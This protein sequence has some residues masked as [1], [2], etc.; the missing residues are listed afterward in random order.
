ML[1]FAPLWIGYALLLIFIAKYS[2][3]RDALLP[4][5]VSVAVQA[6][7]YVATYISAV[8]LVGFGGL[9]YIFGMQ[10]LLIAAGN[11]WLGTWFV[12]RYLAWPTRLWQRKLD[13]K[14]PAELLSKAFDAPALQS[15]IGFI[16]TVLL[17]IY[18]SAVFKGA[19]V[20]IAGVLPISVNTALVCLVAIVGMSVLW[21]GLRGVLYTEAF[22]GLLMIIGVG[23]LL[24]ALL[25]AVGGPA[26]GIK[27]LAALPPT[28][29]AN[30]GFMSLSSGPSGLNIIFLTLVTSVGI[31]AQP[32]LIQR[33]FALKSMSETKKAAPL[34]M[35]A[36]S[37]VVGGAY[38]A[39]ALSRLL[40]GPGI[41]NPDTV[42]PMLVNRL[43]PAF[44]QQLFAL[45]I[46]SASLSTASALL[47]IASGSLGRDVFKKQLT[48]W[49]WR[50]VVIFCTVCSGL[51][52]LKSS[53]IIA[54][55]CATS[56]TLLACAILVPYLALLIQGPKA[57][58]R[59]AL[60]SSA[61]GFAGT[62][63]WYILAYAP[64]SV[65]ITGIAAPGI[66]G[67]LHPLL[68]GI[69]VSFTVFMLF[70]KAW[71]TVTDKQTAA[72]TQ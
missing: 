18:G 63:A 47:H 26:A 42:M 39:S 16:S 71:T 58:G 13:S 59:A 48:G 38:F 61:G 72:D 64:T 52:A 21:G 8:A 11:V 68:P 31:W 3:S 60:L 24:V 28:D 49:S 33:H 62:I 14:T 32:Q 7:A 50:L 70:S 4:G 15:F 1:T 2:C 45:A 19:A 36:L 65:K 35:L 25:H 67:A 41:T 40:L 51:F 53:S 5:K 37:V 44:G 34:A 22:Q 6:L 66:I 23:M 56:W 10:M 30:N 27:A 46:V 29:S 54:M 9:C 57:G 55:I 69:I 12:Y 43:L 20:M 17:I